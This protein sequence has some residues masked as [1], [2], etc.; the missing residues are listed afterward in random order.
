VKEERYSIYFRG[1][2][3]G[4]TTE[5]RSS[6]VNE[7]FTETLMRLTTGPA[8][9]AGLIKEVRVTDDGDFCSFLWLEGK[10]I[11]PTKEDLRELMAE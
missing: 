5:V 8:A 11:F 3:E 4:W 7:K 6:P 2:G 9:V 1:L 10:I